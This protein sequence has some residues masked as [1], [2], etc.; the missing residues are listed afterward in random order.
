M[1]ASRQV[2][3]GRKSIRVLGSR[4]LFNDK[5]KVNTVETGIRAR[6]PWSNRRTRYP[7]IFWGPC[8]YNEKYSMAHSTHSWRCSRLAQLSHISDPGQRS[9]QT[10]Q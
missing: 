1:Q 7:K 2:S 4:R 5:A 3:S 8:L 10:Q 9:P 6:A